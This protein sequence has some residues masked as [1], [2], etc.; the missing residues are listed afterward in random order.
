MS[1]SHHIVI[2][3]IFLDIVIIITE[4]KYGE[5]HEIRRYRDLIF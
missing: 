1:Y 5:P 3:C 4:R 2:N